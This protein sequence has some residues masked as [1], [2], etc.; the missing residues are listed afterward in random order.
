MDFDFAPDDG[1]PAGTLLFTEASPKK[2]ASLHLCR[3]EGALKSFDRGGLEPL[4]STLEQFLALFAEDALAAGA[5][6]EREVEPFQLKR[7]A[8]SRFGG[9]CAF[10][11]GERAYPAS[12]RRRL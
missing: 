7:L 2:R 3:G 11:A 4:D 6:V 1:R 12:R 9:R 8:C 5:F 10:P